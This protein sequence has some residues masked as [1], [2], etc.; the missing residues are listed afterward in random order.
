MKWLEYNLGFELLLIDI[1]FQ[2]VKLNSWDMGFGWT[3][4]KINPFFLLNWQNV[5]WYMNLDFFEKAY[6]VLFT[7]MNCV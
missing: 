2:L 6:G 1:L 3:F 7:W 4:T 5:W